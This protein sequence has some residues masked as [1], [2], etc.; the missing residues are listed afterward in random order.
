MVTDT[1]ILATL[2]TLINYIT[3]YQ[4]NKFF[5]DMIFLGIGA[6]IYITPI[7]DGVGTTIAI[8]N[9]PWGVIIMFVGLAD[10]IYHTIIKKE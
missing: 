6:S 3:I 5:G 10:M 1:I 8:Q 4:H 2:A 9:N 7:L